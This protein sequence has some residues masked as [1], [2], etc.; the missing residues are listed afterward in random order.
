MGNFIIS[1]QPQAITAVPGQDST[2]SVVAST[3]YTPLSSIAYTYQWYTSGVSTQALADKTSSSLVFDPL[4][5]DNG[6]NFV[7]TVTVLSGTTVENLTTY[8]TKLTSQRA[9]LTVQ[10]DVRP[11]DVFDLGSETGRQR[12]LRLRHLGYI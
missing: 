9:L 10:E 3:N 5:E 2:F 7:V 12:H 6:K 8:V 4:I 1:T 11:F